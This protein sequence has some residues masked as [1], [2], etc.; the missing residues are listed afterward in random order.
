MRELRAFILRHGDTD[1][2]DADCFRGMLDP[3]LND[4]GVLGAHKA[5]EFLSRQNIE[6]IICSPLLRAVQTAETVSGK[7]GGRCITQC[8]CLFPWQVASL[9]G[10]DKETH[11][12]EL[13]DFVD[14]PEK[15]PENGECLNDF[16]ERTGDYFEDQLQIKVLTLFVCHTSNIVAL[17]DL[18]QGKKDGRPESGEV[19]EPGGICAVYE[20]EDGYEIEPVF[21]HVK[22]AEFGIS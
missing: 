18:I 12:D 17:N 5:A 14:H 21:G 1:I 22:P 7:I 6:R 20:C 10:K 9:Y 2:N 4:K 19:V 11:Q 13:E 16:I 3:P 15:V 8:R